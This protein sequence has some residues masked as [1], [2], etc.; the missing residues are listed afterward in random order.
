MPPCRSSVSCRLQEK[1]F[2]YIINHVNIVPA[3][4]EFVLKWVVAVGGGWRRG[5][6]TVVVDSM[7]TLISVNL[8][9]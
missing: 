5:E 9:F 1:R 3:V 4:D 2:H 8:M 7:S 6:S